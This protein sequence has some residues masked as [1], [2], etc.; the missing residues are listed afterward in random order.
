MIYTP[1]IASDRKTRDVFFSI[2]DDESIDKSHVV[3]VT[4][5]KIF[6]S[7]RVFITVGACTQYI[8]VNTPSSKGHQFPVLQCCNASGLQ[9]FPQFTIPNSPKAA[10]T[11]MSPDTDV[12]DQSGGKAKSLTMSSYAQ[13][14]AQ[15]GMFGLL[16]NPRGD[17]DEPPKPPVGPGSP[18]SEDK[19]GYDYDYKLDSAASP[20]RLG[21]T[22]VPIT[23]PQARAHQTFRPDSEKQMQEQIKAAVRDFM[24]EKQ[25]ADQADTRQHII[26]LVMPELEWAASQ[27]AKRE[28]DRVIA[29]RTEAKTDE[30]KIAAVVSHLQGLPSRSLEALF[31]KRVMVDLLG[32]VLGRLEREVDDE[33]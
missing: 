32:R 14:I 11:D 13:E 5:D 3:T 7:Q 30:E 26:E 6:D 16:T 19:Y 28:V 29:E 23:A 10:T 12:Q 1:D 24:A 9:L 31:R 2:Y 4:A 33:G 18:C 8:S 15:Q 20:T 25:I 22:G 17:R 21:Y 27:A